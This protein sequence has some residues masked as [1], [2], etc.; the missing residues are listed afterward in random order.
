MWSIV[1]DP[2]N[3]GSRFVNFVVN[4]ISDGT[5][6]ALLK[7][8]TLGGTCAVGTHEQEIMTTE[9]VTFGL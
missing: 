6:F 5:V 2:W 9:R 1:M 8:T 7:S 3:V 4:F